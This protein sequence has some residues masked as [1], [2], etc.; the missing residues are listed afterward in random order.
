MSEKSLEKRFKDAKGFAIGLLILVIILFVIT[1]LLGKMSILSC[2]MRSILI[3]LLI[4][5]I[6]GCK[7]QE[8]YGAICG[9][10]FSIFL[11]LFF[12]IP[13][14]M[15]IGIIEIIFG[16]LYLIDCITLIRKI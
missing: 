5:T 4:G 10:I 6:V 11:I 2:I 16:I 7:N 14:I 3:G 15:S 12:G 8:K 1:L 9:I 13:E